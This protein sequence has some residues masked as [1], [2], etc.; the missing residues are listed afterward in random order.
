MSTVPIAFTFLLC[1][2]PISLLGP[3]WDAVTT[4]KEEVVD[5]LSKRYGY[6][7]RSDDRSS[8]QG[9]PWTLLSEGTTTYNTYLQAD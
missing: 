7:Q 9:L 8:L 2:Q 1:K 4:E 5:V 6:I 3:L